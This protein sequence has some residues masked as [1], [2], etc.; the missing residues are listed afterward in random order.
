MV[1]EI[2]RLAPDDLDAA[3]AL[4][5]LAFADYMNVSLGAGYVRRMLKWFIDSPNGIAL[6]AC[7]PSS[8]LLGFAIG[9]P[10]KAATDL[11]HDLLPSACWGL[12]THPW[13]LFQK[14][15]RQTVL[16]RMKG[17][18]CSVQATAAI[19][20][21]SISLFGIAVHPAAHR[22]GVGKRLLQEFE[23]IAVARSTTAIYLSVFPDNLAA[24]N[25]YEHLG[26]QL[27]R[28]PQHAE[29]AVEYVKYIANE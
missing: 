6:A 25:L 12:L 9:A 15:I 22:C 14:R 19:E 21:P 24:R 18:F 3:T 13:I 29:A 10:T 5:C 4:H 28:G 20:P 11:T 7:N 23:A 26:W 1:I 2:R 27:M 16:S 8:E 17:L